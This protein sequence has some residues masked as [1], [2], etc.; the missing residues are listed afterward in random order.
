MGVVM[1]GPKAA[2]SYPR[3]GE[4]V[5]PLVLR[6][7]LAQ[8]IPQAL[9]N[10]Y[11]AA[12]L[13][14]CDLDERVWRRFSPE[15]IKELAQAVVD[16][17]S[18]TRMLNALRA[19]RFPRLWA[20]LRLDELP[21]E[22]RT[23]RCLEREGFDDQPQRLSSCTLGDL[24]SIRSFGPR[25]LLDL[26]TAAEALQKK[27]GRA[28]ADEA[29]Y[30]ELSAELTAE[31]EKIAALNEARSVRSDDPRFGGWIQAIDSKTRTAFEL[32]EQ[33]RRRTRDP[34]DPGYVLDHI[35]QLR[36]GIERMS[37]LSL[38]DELI[39]I[40]ATARSARNREVI[41]AYYGWAE[42][43]THTLMEIGDRFGITRE[44]VRQIC[45]KLTKKKRGT[46]VILAPVMDRALALIEKSMPV[47]ARELEA[48]LIEKGLTAVGMSM[49]AVAAGAK[50]LNRPIPFKIVKVEEGKAFAAGRA[51]TKIKKQ[52]TAKQQ[53]AKREAGE[54]LVVRPEQVNAVTF[55]ADQAKKEV[56]FHGLAKVAEM[57]R[58]I[59]RRSRGPINGQL[60]RQTLMLVEG[61]HWLDEH[62]GWY[63]IRGI[64]KHGLPKAIGKVLAVAADVTVTQLRMALARN[65]RLWKEPPPEKV[66]L[67]YCRL[68]SGVRVEGKHIRSDPP[69]NWKK[70]LAGVEA[71]L[72]EVLKKHGP[73]MDRG[74]MEDLCVGAGMNRF[75]FHAFVSWSP[76]IV[77]FGPSVYGLLGAKVTHDQVD[78]MLAA[79]RAKRKS[80][81]VLSDHGVNKA[82]NVWLRYRLSKAASTYAVITIPAGLKKIVRGRF[83]LL[84][85]DGK[86]IGT[87]ATKEG[88]AW[89]LGAYLRK[90]KAKFGD[91]ITLTID[92]A[93]RT[94]AVRWEKEEPRAKGKRLEKG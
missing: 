2:N 89:G 53:G 55:I 36:Q 68:L 90:C 62:S 18:T 29:A 72:V 67:E 34:A 82:G 28:K 11:G 74:S 71:Q 57:E 12:E 21:L 16:F 61:F 45:A 35:R 10:R 41:I 7:F 19:R 63:A 32:A 23:R 56:Y 48:K 46:G 14:L 87:L 88:R 70:V 6:D 86:A 42:G 83:Q 60:V 24:L 37:H 9:S 40:F 92:L 52:F 85:P 26:L 27:A 8:P 66:L 49:E 5:A 69:R 15:A 81:R 22:N 54:C 91:L 78:K 79:T 3:S 43:Q 39:E 59:A 25:C 51:K 20:G 65:R 73:L 17:I 64:A 30:A 4:C 94:A 13:K 77:Q 44:R 58:M 47:T 80:Y 38:E 33:L 50:L 76:V 93:K 1:V 84:A 31:A 75:S